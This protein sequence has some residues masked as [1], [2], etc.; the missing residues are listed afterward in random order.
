MLTAFAGPHATHAQTTGEA[1]SDA[2]AI[3]MCSK[4]SVPQSNNPVVRDL[5]TEYRDL[6]FDFCRV[7][8]DYKDGGFPGMFE[9]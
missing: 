1:A 3:S 6:T 7:K 4:P 8:E 5:L 2:L 9:R